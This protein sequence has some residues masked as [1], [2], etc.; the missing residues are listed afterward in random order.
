MT[1]TQTS[2]PQAAA[3]QY[4]AVKEHVYGFIKQL[5]A[6]GHNR[7]VRLQ[8]RTSETEFATITGNGDALSKKTDF[9][10]TIQFR[11]P[12]PPAKAK[13]AFKKLIEWM[14]PAG[15]RYL[16]FPGELSATGKT[17]YYSLGFIKESHS[18]QSGGAPASAGSVNGKHIRWVGDYWAVTA[19]KVAQIHKEKDGHGLE[20]HRVAIH[21]HN[22]KI[23]HEAKVKTL[24]EAQEKVKIQLAS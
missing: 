3:P 1:T 17:A 9:A 6:H 8:A 14:K 10:I 15:Y 20:A 24:A 18:E 13:Q 19:T 22:N 7:F 11:K 12:C 5:E 23:L 21:T 4:S 2:P 16:F